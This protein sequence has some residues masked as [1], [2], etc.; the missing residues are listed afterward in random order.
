MMEWLRRRP[1]QLDHFEGDDRSLASSIRSGLP[2]DQTDAASSVDVHSETSSRGD[3]IELV[4]A[5]L[6][7]WLWRSRGKTG[8]F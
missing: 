4:C 1:I 8:G 3:E 6:F 2:H 5:V 7:K